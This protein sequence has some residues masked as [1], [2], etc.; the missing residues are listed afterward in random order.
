[1]VDVSTE[2]T[3]ER[4]A[5][6][7]T[8][9]ALVVEWMDPAE[10]VLGENI[11]EVRPDPAM[12]AS[13]RD[14]GVL[15]PV[16]AV[17]TAEGRIKVRRGAHRTVCAIEAGAQIPVI[18][19]GDEGTTTE[20]EVDRIVAQYSENKY[21]RL[22]KPSE[23]AA[24]AV[25]LSIK[26]LSDTKIGKRLRMS[27][28][29]VKAAK[30]VA[31]SEAASAA[32]DEYDLDIMQAAIVAEFADD[33][34]RVESLVWRARN[35]GSL[36]HLAA[37]YRQADKDKA[38][39]AAYV[40]DLE[41]QGLR[42]V[43][44]VPGSVGSLQYLEYLADADGVP[45]DQEAHLSCPG[46][47]V[48][49]DQAMVWVAPDGRVFEDDDDIPEELRGEVQDDYVW[50]SIPVCDQAGLHS[51]RTWNQDTGSTGSGDGEGFAAPTLDAEQVREQKRVA[52]AA[53]IA[54]NK[55]WDAAVTVRREWVSGFLQRKTMPAGA[56][57]FLTREL[58]T[59]HYAVADAFRDGH[60][61]AAD[62]LG[63]DPVGTGEY[64]D[65]HWFG[66]TA[67]GLRKAADQASD[68][69]RLVLLLGVVLAGNEKALNRQSWR[70]D[71][72]R[73]QVGCAQRDYL[74]F[75]V[76]QGYGACPVE[77]QAA[78]LPTGLDAD[79][80]TGAQVAEQP[81]EETG[82]DQD[83]DDQDADDQ[84]GEGESPEEAEQVA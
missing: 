83:A 62:L 77:L 81:G 75:I 48:R 7:T 25:Q 74:R 13:I 33:P 71:D 2:Q 18:V 38:A 26:G 43:Q 51:R 32:L 1:M 57:E 30:A 60:P 66:A 11:W 64:V 54:G 31:G 47:A 6:N 3:A 45:L 44:T 58:L 36:E 29:Q 52:R 12:V 59:A 80:E 55:E 46:H 27:R 4:T 16:T 8:G 69:R 65:N 41:T 63:I 39:K 22:M 49:V 14:V 42:V 15:E 68:K 40:E 76:S 34:E 61:L 72:H 24:V 21:R 67:L 82:D 78:G 56:V 20:D 5:E 28:P 70:K 53:V 84:D 19:V 23:D 35:S 9:T 10:L 73:K 50:R 79:L 37:H 17:R